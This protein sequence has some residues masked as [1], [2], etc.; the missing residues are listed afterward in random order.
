MDTPGSLLPPHDLPAS[1]FDGCFLVT[2]LT[3]LDRL[4]PS[5]CVISVVSSQTINWLFWI[6][7]ALLGQLG[8]VPEGNRKGAGKRQGAVG[9]TVPLGK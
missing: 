5:F 4:R 2:F 8:N 3:K 7:S 9:R 6:M 1:A